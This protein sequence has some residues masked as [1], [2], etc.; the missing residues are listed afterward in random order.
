MFES[1]ISGLDTIII[2]CVSAFGGYLGAYFKKSAEIS[3]MS[4]N[5]KELMSQQ[6]KI[7]E[8]TESVKQDIE[9][10]V[11]RKK[12]QELLKREKMEEFAIL[13]I[14]LPQKLSDEYSKRTIHKNAD[15]D[16]HYMKKIILLQSLYL[17]KFA[18]DMDSLMSLHQRYEALVA[19][20]HKHTRPSLPYL[21]SK[22]AEFVKVR[23]ELECFSAFIVGKVST[24]IENMGHA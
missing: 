3:S 4:D 7:T 21:E 23:T 19:E 13:C 8:A 22:L 9:H 18:N 10:Q 20:I 17:P 15:Y 5:I 1:N 2:A 12:E 24:E 11:W 6:R 14:E 16:R